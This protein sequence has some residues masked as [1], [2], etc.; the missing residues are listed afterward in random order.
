MLITTAYFDRSEKTIEGFFTLRTV[1]RDDSDPSKVRII[2]EFSKLPSRSGLKG[3][4][5][6]SWERSRS[7]IPWTRNANVEAVKKKPLQFPE[8]LWIWLRLVLQEGL[9]AGD[10]GIGEFRYIS[11]GLTEPSIIRSPSDPSLVREAVGIHPENGRKGSLGCIVLLVN[12][13]EQR[14]KVLELQSYVKKLA[15]TTKLIRLEV[16]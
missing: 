10:K 6:T 9:W 12:T 2:K 13:E 16:I 1:E 4:E 8:C 11:S 7:P 5:K 14:K 3:A 15:S